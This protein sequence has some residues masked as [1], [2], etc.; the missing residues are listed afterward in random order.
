MGKAQSQAAKARKSRL[1]YETRIEA[2]LAG[3]YDDH[4]KGL[5]TSIRKL[6]RDSGLPYKTLQDRING[7]AKSLSEESASRGRLFPE[8]TDV[9]IDHSLH[10][11]KR[12]C[13]VTVAGIEKRANE[14]LSAREG[15]D[16]TPVG[17]NWADRFMTRHRTRLQTYWGA[18]LDTK[19]G[20]ALNP[21][22]NKHYWEGIET[23]IDNN[24]HPIPP[25]RRYGTDEIG[26]NMGLATK[27]RVVGPAGQKIQHVQGD[28]E[29]EM[30]TVVNTI[31]ADGT[32]LRPT[33]I[34]KGKN[35]LQRWSKQENPLNVK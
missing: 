15:T 11:A 23:I 3:Y 9:L 2:A 17:N 16:F 18:S 28:A 26:F 29:R 5:D 19:R 27:R 24:G 1:A 6:Q 35:W 21:T 33:V 34:Y 30:V 22:S 20:Q 4:S 7:G 13:P 12:G 25:H 32:S 14:I 10:M 31:C 8:E